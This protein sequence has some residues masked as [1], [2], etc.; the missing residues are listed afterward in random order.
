ML[1]GT[2]IIG[3]PTITLISGFT[4]KDDTL[5]ERFFGSGGINRTVFEKALEEY[6]R[7]RGWNDEGGC[8]LR[9]NWGSLVYSKY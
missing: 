7:F 3:H 4:R 5:P 1:Q 6:Y 9:R 8:R 2:D